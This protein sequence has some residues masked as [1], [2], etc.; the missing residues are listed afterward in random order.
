MEQYTLKE[1]AKLGPRRRK[2]LDMPYTKRPL[3][4]D[5][6]WSLL[7]LKDLAEPV[8]KGWAGAKERII[9]QRSLIVYLA[10]ELLIEKISNSNCF[11]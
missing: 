10:R 5:D 8:F 9:D 1:L 4:I 6:L 11:G 2:D 7:E 3:T